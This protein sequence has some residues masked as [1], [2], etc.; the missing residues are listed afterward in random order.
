MSQLG[1]ITGLAREADCF[2]ALPSQ[3]GLLVRCA[4]GN[5]ERAA[6]IAGILVANGCRGLA[7]FGIAG[8]LQPG[9]DPG[10]IVIAGSVICPDN[11]RIQCD[12]AWQLNLMS[13]L[14]RELFVVGSDLCGRDQAV[15]LSAQK[16][17]LHDQTA[18]AAVDMESHAVAQVAAELGVPFIAIRAIADPLDR[19]VPSWVTDVVGNDGRPRAGAVIAGVARHP[20][21]VPALMRLGADTEKAIASLRR[22][23]LTAGPFLQ[24]RL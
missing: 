4:G 3:R 9:L 11:S 6:E 8:G 5:S 17:R 16:R 12:P 21:D 18:A 22:V 2:R 15:L 14:E 13:A 19:D 24:L 20:F 7:S 10:A 1:V 23:A